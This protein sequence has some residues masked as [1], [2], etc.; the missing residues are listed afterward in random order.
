MWIF[1][2]KFNSMEEI[3]T[4]LTELLQLKYDNNNDGINAGNDNS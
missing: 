4:E 3:R 2:K 1:I